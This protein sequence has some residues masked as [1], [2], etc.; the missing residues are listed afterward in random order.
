MQAVWKMKID[1]ASFCQMWEVDVSR[2]PKKHNIQFFVHEK[3]S[4][5]KVSHKKMM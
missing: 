3:D 4:N 1:E 5:Y 2:T